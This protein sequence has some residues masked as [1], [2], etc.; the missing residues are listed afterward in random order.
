VDTIDISSLS[1]TR[2]LLEGGRRGRRRRPG[3]PPLAAETRGLIER[4][5]RENPRWGYMRIEG[6]LLKLGI[7]VSATT[8]ATVLRRPGLGPAPR[9]LGPSWPEFLRA[10]A[11]SLLGSE[12]RSSVGAGREDDA[13]VR[14]GP[15]PDGEARHV[16]TD[17]TLSAIDAD[18]PRLV[19]RPL[20]RP[21]PAQCP[22]GAA[23]SRRS[24]DRAPAAIASIARPRRTP[25]G[26]RR[27][28]ATNGSGIR[29]A[30]AASPYRPDK[31]ALPPPGRPQGSSPTPFRRNGS[32]TTPAGSLNRI[33]LPH[34]YSTPP[35]STGENGMTADAGLPAPSKGRRCPFGE[36]A[37]GQV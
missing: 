12:L 14:T 1:G 16:E 36:P 26:G 24:E 33:S 28:T 37:S 10:Q 8:I 32:T 21:R 25:T 5:A 29:E 35:H 18:E 34:T 31:P 27:S 9:R 11:Y 2:A 17:D 6:E 23:F 13:S 7:S 3:R 30:V 19:S 20:A 22:R 4:M 15:A